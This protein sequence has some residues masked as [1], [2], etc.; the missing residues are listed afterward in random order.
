MLPLWRRI[1]NKN[2]RTIQLQEMENEQKSTTS[3]KAS[4]EEDIE[5]FEPSFRKTRVS[6][7]CSTMTNG[8]TH[9]P[10]FGQQAY[11][12]HANQPFSNSW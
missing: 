5:E 9:P 6:A 1:M 8:Q 10:P 2:S 11:A 7:G 3:V 12:Y 4:Y